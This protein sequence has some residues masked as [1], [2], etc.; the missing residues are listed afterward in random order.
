MIRIIIDW[1][2]VSQ[3]LGVASGICTVADVSFMIT[4]PKN[5]Q[6]IRFKIKVER[7]SI[8]FTGMSEGEGIPTKEFEKYRKEITEMAHAYH[9]GLL[10]EKSTFYWYEDEDIDHVQSRI[11]DM[12][13]STI[14]HRQEIQT[15]QN[16]IYKEVIQDEDK[17]KRKRKKK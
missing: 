4:P 10:L 17:R 14:K 2:F 8:G 1:D 12:K 11:G 7:G 3:T 15:D 9:Y 5:E 6:I 16:V 13:Y